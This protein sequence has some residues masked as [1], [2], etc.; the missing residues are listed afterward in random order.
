VPLTSQNAS[1]MPRFLLTLQCPDR[2]GI[3]HG[4]AEALLAAEA[5]ILENDQFREVVSGAFCMRTRFETPRADADAVRVH[6][7]A[8]ASRF[9]A[10]LTVRA[11]AA[12]TRTLIMVSKFDHCLSDLLYRWRA[13]ELPIDIP[14]VVSNHFDCQELVARHGIPF[15]H[16]PITSA[17]K[18]AQEARLSELVDQHK[19]DLIVLARYMQ[20]LSTD[21]CQRFSERVI[22]IHHSFLPGFKGAKPYHQAFERGVKIIG[23]TAH[24]VTSDLDEG[25]IIEQDVF[26]VDHAYEA[27]DL[28]IVGRDVERQV[29]ARAVKLHAEDRLIRIGNRVVVFD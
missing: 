3:V 10:R 4:V 13:D 9:G 18:V 27:E 2:P 21:L 22:N 1:E 28:A 5:N 14:L 11:E 8:V 25:P 6:L 26:R 17:T 23:A 19:V 15:I 7:E 24:Y 16:L 29:L 12:R 20:I